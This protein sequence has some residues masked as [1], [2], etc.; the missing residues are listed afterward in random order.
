[1]NL[2]PESGAVA[3]LVARLR[4]A[5]LAKH[6][7]QRAY[8]ASL[9]A[10][11]YVVHRIAAFRKIPAEAIEARALLASQEA[12][13][14]ADEAVHSLSMAL[15]GMTKVLAGINRRI[16]T[17]EAAQSETRRE[18]L[19]LSTDVVDVETALREID[20]QL[21]ALMRHTDMP[22]PPHTHGRRPPI[23]TDSRSARPKK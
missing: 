11:A 14:Y 22:V 17:L 16:D 10:H 12:K 21:G 1:M 2:A 4:Y 13:A 20:A 9:K 8:A 23:S 6:I 19:D 3:K 5:A 18:I 7:E 15:R